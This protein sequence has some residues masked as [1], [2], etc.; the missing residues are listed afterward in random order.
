MCSK[1]KEDKKRRTDE[2]QF[3]IGEKVVHIPEGVCRI[4]EITTMD[5]FNESKEYYK[6]IPAMGEPCAIYVSV[7]GANKNIRKLRSRE[8]IMEILEM[9]KKSKMHWEKREDRRISQIKAAVYGDDG[10]A[11]AKWIKVYHLRR[12]QEHLNIND[13]NLLKKAEQLFYSEMSVVLKKDYNKLRSQTLNE[14]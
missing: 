12:K 2:Q 11:L 1:A 7:N 6:L 14:K 9:Q 13:S 8:E 5:Y 10:I 3:R 4:E